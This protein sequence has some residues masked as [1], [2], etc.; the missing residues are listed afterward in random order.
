M[1]SIGKGAKSYLVLPEDPKVDKECC[2]LTCPKVDC[3]KPMKPEVLFRANRKLGNLCMRMCSV[4]NERIGD[5]RYYL[6]TDSKLLR[7]RCH[8]CLIAYLALC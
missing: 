4:C 1:G 2:R 8:D 6:P 7:W 3:K 5:Y